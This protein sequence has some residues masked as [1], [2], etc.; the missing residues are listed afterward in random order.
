MI[1]PGEKLKAWRTETAKITQEEAAGRINA[2]AATW[3]DLEAGKKLPG[4]D[5]AADLERLTEGAVTVLDWT[6]LSRERREGRK[7]RRERDETPD[8]AEG[9]GAA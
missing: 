9:K 8:G 4:L 1:N 5:I 3:C 6:E 7:R 2:S